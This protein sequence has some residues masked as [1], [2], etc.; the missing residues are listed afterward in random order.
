MNFLKKNKI[1]LTLS[2]VIFRFRNK[3]KFCT[4]K[5][6]IVRKKKEKKKKRI[7]YTTKKP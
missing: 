4:K 6:L 5:M 7:I 3:A 1:P 2:Q